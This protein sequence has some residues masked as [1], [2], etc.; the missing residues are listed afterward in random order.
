M[1]RLTSMRVFLRVV[2]E[3]GFAA[4]A[5]ALDMSP[6][7]VTRL[8]ADLEDHL[9]TRL[10][11]RTT[12]RQSLTDAGEAYLDR[13]RHIL[14][15]L[16]DAHSLVSSQ[17][18][19]LSGTLRVLAPPVLAMHVL[20]PLV[21]SFHLRYPQIQL[22]IEVASHREPP[23]EAFDITLMGTDAGFD[24]DIIA[25]KIT[26]TETFLVA[27]PAYL[28]RRGTPAAPQ[29]LLQHDCLRIKPD[30]GPRSRL[31]RLFRSDSDEEVQLEVRPVL[32][33]NHTDTVMRAALDGAG[34]TG[35]TVELAAPY[36]ASGALVR[37][38]APWI[39]GRF[40]LYAAL[41]SRK[42]LP[43]RTQVFLDHLT[44]NTRERIA[45]ALAGCDAC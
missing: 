18:Q 1:D 32:W 43:Q 22:D 4:A 36:L 41:P 21:A 35:A 29:D 34:I 45:Q 24:G 7:V 25:R 26:D 33:V 11:Q 20:A 40:T 6:A 2:D 13:V 15:D 17:T 16:D 39:T 10:L 19:E 38:L 8:V 44:D 27:S 9:G 37:V 31:W 14:Q 23:I 30:M 12:R 28:A 3:G 42:F 5:R